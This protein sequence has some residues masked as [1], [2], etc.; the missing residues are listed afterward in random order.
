MCDRY[1]LPRDESGAINAHDGVFFIFAWTFISPNIIYTRVVFYQYA[2][3]VASHAISTL[4]LLV[5]RHFM[6]NIW[7]SGLLQSISL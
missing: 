1:V 5:G 2:W 4:H 6:Q 7:W 3:R